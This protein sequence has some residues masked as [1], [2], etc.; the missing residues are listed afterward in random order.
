[1]RKLTLT[2]DGAAL[3]TGYTL[4]TD[5]PV[6]PDAYQ[7]QAPGSG[8]VFVTKLDPRQR[9]EAGLVYSTYFGG[10]SSEVAYDILADAEKNI[11]L[12]GYTLSGDLPVSSDAF[13]PYASGGVDVF[14]AKLS[15]AAPPAQ[16]LVYATFAGRGGINVG[17]G[18]AVSADGV[19]YVAGRSQDQSFPVTENALQPAHAGGFSD[20]FILALGKKQ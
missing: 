14:C 9:G 15:L 2:A 5:F 8:D 10:S 17:Y 18:I 7:E 13:Q 3:L 1:V 20:G 19:I 4:S 11:Y 12:T 6:T 16:A